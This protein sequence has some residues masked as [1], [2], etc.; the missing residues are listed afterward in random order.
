MRVGV[1][2]VA[3]NG[4][5]WLKSALDSCA[6]YASGLPVYVVD[7][8]SSDGS[9]DLV[10]SQFPQVKLLRQTEN[11]GFTGGN[12]IGLR[13]AVAASAEAVLLLNQDAELQEQTIALLVNYLEQHPQVAA[14]QPAIFLPDGRVNTLGNCWHYLGFGYGGG[15]GL[16]IKEASARLPW[17]NGR[18]EIPYV[19]GAAVLVRTAAL[20]QVG[21][22]DSELFLYHE[23]LELSLRLRLAGWG[24]ALEPAARAIHHY[25]FSRS[26][27]KFYYM[28]RNRWL[29]WLWYWKW[30][31]LV[32]LGSLMLLAELPLLLVAGGSGWF[33]VKFRVYKYFGRA[34]TLRSIINHRQRLKALRVVSDR[35]LLSLASAKVSFQ[36]VDSW[37]TRRI[38]NPLAAAVWWLIYPLIRW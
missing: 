31:T 22:F 27:S 11:L 6:K 23:D 18:Q 1:V 33:K 8:A 9:A 38:F 28:E 30:P 5:R 26:L 35:Q 16:D 34:S 24:L 36:E 14:V 15:H 25:E 20:Q 29:V 12:N 10:A 7:N 21:F 19:S 37:L 2:I 13:A 32:I 4:R 17:L 3:Y